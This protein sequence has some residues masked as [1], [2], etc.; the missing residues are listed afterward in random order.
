MITRQ[1]ILSG[2]RSVFA[3][4]SSIIPVLRVARQ[5]RHRKGHIPPPLNRNTTECKAWPISN[6]GL[7]VDVEIIFE[8]VN[9]RLFLQ[10]GFIENLKLAQI[11]DRVGAN[12]LRMQLVEMQGVPEKLLSGR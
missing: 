6:F 8:E 2:W 3:V 4:K 9:G 7:A 5:S 11:G 10:I 12:V 1:W